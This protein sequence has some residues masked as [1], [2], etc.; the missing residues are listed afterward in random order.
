MLE[1]EI[2]QGFSRSEVF[3]TLNRVRTRFCKP[4]VSEPTF[5]RWLGELGIT[6]KFRYSVKEVKRL[7]RLCLHYCQG[8]KTTNFQ[9]LED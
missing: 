2:L 3:L 7:Q 8:G 9:D 5:Y 1:T 4:P 6:P